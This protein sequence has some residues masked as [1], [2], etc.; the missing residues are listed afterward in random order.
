M[1]RNSGSTEKNTNYASRLSQTSGAQWRKYGF[2]PDVA[3]SAERKKWITPCLLE[4]SGAHDEKTLITACQE[5]GLNREKRKLQGISNVQA[6]PAHRS[7]PFAV[8]V[9]EGNYH[10]L[11]ATSFIRLPANAAN[12]ISY[13]GV[14]ENSKDSELWQKQAHRVVFR[15]ISRFHCS[16]NFP[17][18]SAL[19][20]LLYFAIVLSRRRI[21]PWRC[22]LTSSSSTCRSVISKCLILYL[23][24][25]PVTGS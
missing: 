14:R 16:A 6:M 20:I 12:L 3:N 10:S 21:R 2:R 17:F 15:S 25:V 18:I 13:R 22:S 4:T 8:D 24:V 9:V 19:D 7:F 5:I 11:R 1:F 23:D